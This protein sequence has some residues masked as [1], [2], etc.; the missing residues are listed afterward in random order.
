[1]F[2]VESIKKLSGTN[3]DDLDKTIDKMVQ[4]SAN[5]LSFRRIWARQVYLN[6]K[7]L[8]MSRLKWQRIEYIGSKD[9]QRKDLTRYFA[10]IWPHGN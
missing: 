5:V 10:A 4:S 2:L 9:C 7:P 6:R 1:M 8:L 3:N